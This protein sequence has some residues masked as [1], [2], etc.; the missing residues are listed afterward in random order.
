MYIIFSVVISLTVSRSGLTRGGC[1]MFDLISKKETSKI[2]KKLIG[3]LVEKYSFYEISIKLN[4][5]EKTIYKW[6]SGYIP[7]ADN[8][9]N[10]QLL[11]STLSL[12]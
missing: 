1:Y 11:H 6:R 9:L 3:D 7:K 10:L 8:F 2:V 12:T 4:V 5:N